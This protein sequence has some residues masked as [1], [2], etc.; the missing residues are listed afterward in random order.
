MNETILVVDDEPKIAKLARDYLERGG[1]RVVT[2]PAGAPPRA[3]RTSRGSSAPVIWRS[4]GTAVAAGVMRSRF[5]SPALNSTFWRFWLDIP[6]RPSPVLN[7]STACTEWLTK[8]L[9][10][11]S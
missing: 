3:A 10:G 9:T 1:L 4:I 11:V 6:D 7:S 5:S 8:V 2:A